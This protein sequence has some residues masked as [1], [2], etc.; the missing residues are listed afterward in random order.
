LVPETNTLSPP[1]PG[2][3]CNDWTYDGFST[4]ADSEWGGVATDGTIYYYFDSDTVYTGNPPDGHGGPH[5]EGEIGAPGTGHGGS[6][7]AGTA[8][9]KSILCCSACGLP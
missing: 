6:C 3:R 7:H 8:E 2:G 4:I 1:G 5:Y 9:P